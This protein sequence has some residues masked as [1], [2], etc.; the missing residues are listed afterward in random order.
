MSRPALREDGRVVEALLVFLQQL[1]AHARWLFVALLAL[2]ALSGIRTIPPHET[3]LVRRFG[4]LQPKLHGPGL[5]LGLPRPF[6][7]VLRFETAKE[8][9]LP[10]DDWASGGAKIGDPDKPLPIPDAELQR[11][12]AARE[13]QGG[14]IYAE[15]PDQAGTTLD[16]LVHGYT[17]TAD[18]NVLQGRFTL[19]YRIEDPFRFTAVGDRVADLLACLGYRALAL[20]LANRPIDASL[21]ADRRDVASQ[22]AQDVQAEVDRHGLGVRVTGLDIRELAPP[23]QVLAAFEDVTNARQFAKTLYENSRQYHAE[24]LA[25]SE[26]E[27]AAIQQRALGHATTL[28]E[29]ARGEAA[30]FTA[31]LADYQRQPALVGRRLLRE[32]LDTALQQIPS[33]TL[34]PAGRAQPT[35]I[36]EPQPEFAR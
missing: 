13:T 22:A 30:A 2:Y 5:L 34:L 35:L 15:Y 29:I 32:S 14:S 36:L 9:S 23:N 24:T 6:D 11:R 27:S 8:V 1:T 21:T 17:I 3:A 25:K 7:E 4:Q 28:V 20:Q 18:V 31:L 16:P 33:R 26:G 10:L 12:R 19:R